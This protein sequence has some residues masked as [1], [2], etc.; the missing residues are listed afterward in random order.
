MTYYVLQM[1]LLGWVDVLL[2]GLDFVSCVH[3][4]FVS[5]VAD[6]KVNE[7]F[8][9]HLD[10]VYGL[11]KSLLCIMVMLSVAENF[12]LRYSSLVGCSKFCIA[13]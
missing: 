1:L 7:I 5:R 6:S 4:M 3:Q 10:D 11:L 12:Q 9:L 8:V 2:R 13:L